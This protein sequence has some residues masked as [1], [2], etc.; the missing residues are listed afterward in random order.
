MHNV[1]CGYNA[2]KACL[3]HVTTQCRASG[4]R[5][6]MAEP[7]VGQYDG[8]TKKTS[9]SSKPSSATTAG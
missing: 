4:P 6:S 8:T 5:I 9:D 2:H 3:N 1:D 7:V